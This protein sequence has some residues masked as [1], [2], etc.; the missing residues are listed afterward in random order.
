[1]D[2][3]TG[4]DLE[5]VLS[6]ARPRSHAQVLQPAQPLAYVVG[7]GI[8]TLV[9]HRAPGYLTTLGSMTLMKL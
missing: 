5:G 9:C 2:G 1:M 7:L 8:I 6:P 3:A 4:S